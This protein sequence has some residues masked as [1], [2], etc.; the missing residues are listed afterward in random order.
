VHGEKEAADALRLELAKVGLEN[1][2][3]PEWFERVEL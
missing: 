1:V 3:Y 2:H